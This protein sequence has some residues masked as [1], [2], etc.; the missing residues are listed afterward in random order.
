[1]NRGFE[2]GVVNH[3]TGSSVGKP[4]NL[5]VQATRREQKIAGRWIT[6]KLLG[7]YLSQRYSKSISGG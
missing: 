4:E 5:V 3:R 1:M 6:D 2:P 7:E